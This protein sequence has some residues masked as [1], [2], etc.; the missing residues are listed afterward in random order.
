MENLM[1][2]I[3]SFRRRWTGTVIVLVLTLA[4][5]ACDAQKALARKRQKSVEKGL[6]RTVYLKGL[7]P[8]PLALR[9]RMAFYR[10]PG[11]SVRAFDKSRAEWGEAFGEA[12]AQTR[13]RLE[14]ETI[15]QAGGLAQMMTA[16]AA[17]RL[18]RDG[19]IDLDEDVRTRLKSWSFPAD[20]RLPVGVLT[21]RRLLTHSAGLSDQILDGSGP[22]DALP[23]IAQI[24]SG[25]KPA[26]NAPVWSPTRF[27]AGRKAW[28]SEGGYVLVQQ[29]LEEATGLPFEALMKRTIID[30]LGLKNTLFA[31]DLPEAWAGQA[32][33][34]HTREGAALPGRWRRYPETAAKGLWTTADDYAAFLCELL[35][36]AMGRSEKLLAPAE[37]RVLLSPQIENFAFGF[38]A[39]GRGDDINF[40]FQA[41]TAGFAAGFTVYPAKGQGIVL[42]TNS[43]NGEFLAEEI[44]AACSKAYDW[45]H[46]KPME[47]DVLR[48]APETYRA[49]AGRFEVNPSYGLDITWEDYYLV[50]RPTGQ[51]ATK[52][53]AEGQ[54]LF[55]STDPYIRIQFYKD[56]TGTVTSLSL[57]QKDFE[58]EAKKVR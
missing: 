30:P 58:L 11:L 4:V 43:D 2:R 13:R 22:D 14:P 53:Y 28:I 17:F 35:D 39:D 8:E 20:A 10:V 52:F 54:T 37:A 19:S 7:Q 32:A 6:L 29:C 38:L 49:F 41:R 31:A 18:A 26:G 46:Y 40:H 21:L 1:N 3:F 55:Y 36:E 57:W 9:E 5:S 34:G 12:D 56:K 44:L 33:V 16:A 27:G 42:L 45:P 47:K 25:Q 24:L 51:A 15:F 48:L 23:T 50:I